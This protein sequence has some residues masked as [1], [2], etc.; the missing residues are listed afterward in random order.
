MADFVRLDMRHGLPESRVRCLGQTPDGRL[1]VVTAGTISLYDGTNFHVFNLQPH[2]AYPLTAYLGNRHLTCDSTGIAWLRNG[3]CLYAL[4][5][6]RNLLVQN[7]DSLMAARG[8]TAD[9]ICHWP[10]E[11]PWQQSADYE[12]VK[13]VTDEDISCV[14]RDSYGTLWTGL[15][16][17][18]LLYYNPTRQREF[19]T[20]DKPYV[21]DK[22]Y[23]FCSPRASEISARF[24]PAATNCT[25]DGRDMAYTFLG[26]RQGI[27][28]INR[29]E[30]LVGTIDESYGLSTNNVTSLIRD[31]SG[32]VWAATANGLSRLYQTGRDSFAIVSYGFLDGVD[33][34]GREF[35]TCQIHR[36][37]S[38]FITVGFA[39]GTCVFQPDSVSAPRYTFYFP[40]AV[41]AG[42]A[43]DSSKTEGRSGW[44]R[45]WWQLLVVLFVAAASAWLAV[46]VAKRRWQER[47][48][49]KRE[50][51]ETTTIADEVVQHLAEDSSQSSADE[52]FIEKL[53]T[54]IEQHLADDDFSVQTLSEMMAMDRTVLYRR[55]QT[56]TG[57]SPSA[58]IKGI[59][60]SV[61]QK[62]L[63]DT[64]MSLSDIAS[65]TGFSTTKY[66]SSSFKD[67][68]GLTPGEYREQHVTESSAGQRRHA[69]YR[70]S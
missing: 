34:H 49:G 59:R 63:T 4:D 2:Y 41:D 37:A 15:K 38:G 45:W 57:V 26:T 64:D 48:A 3:G 17:G 68:F 8:L 58:Y 35:G 61:A 10:S 22:Q 14:L 56:L 16:E 39:G 62:L 47:K 30:Q 40:R 28:I 50:G 19:L 70:P 31:L 5:T 54:T 36:D 46:I 25:L 23:P 7:I 51:A 33:T 18:G 6:S 44:V 55:M 69:S 1:V 20:T 53:H 43:D 67:N 66:F 21:Y 32:N 52:Q 65:K 24:A 12:R 60:M 42:Y 29:Q 27:M 9:Q 11:Q 13:A